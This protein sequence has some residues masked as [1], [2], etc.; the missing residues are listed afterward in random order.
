VGVG[1]MMVG[2]HNLI[3]AF[4]EPFAVIYSPEFVDIIQATTTANSIAFMS[5]TYMF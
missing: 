2:M 5:M 1:A 4:P 3:W